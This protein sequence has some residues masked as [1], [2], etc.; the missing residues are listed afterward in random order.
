MA[1]IRPSWQNG[2][3]KLPLLVFELVV[4]ESKSNCTNLY[5]RNASL[6]CY[7]VCLSM[8][9][10]VLGYNIELELNLKLFRLLKITIFCDPQSIENCGF[11][12]PKGS[13]AK[14]RHVLWLNCKMQGGTSNQ[15]FHK[16][17]IKLHEAPKSCYFSFKCSIVMTLF[18]CV[19]FFV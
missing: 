11:S 9:R 13:K 4:L 5:G 15:R 3:G 8:F 7:N 14:M 17:Y 12:G 19:I 18:S 6:W 10:Y 2:H 16:M 1:V